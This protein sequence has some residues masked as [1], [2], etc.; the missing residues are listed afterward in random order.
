MVGSRIFVMFVLMRSGG[1]RGSGGRWMG[2]TVIGFDEG[3]RQ[4]HGQYYL[5]GVGQR[6][7]GGV[8]D[9]GGG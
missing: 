7:S 4:Q 3:G 8:G 5:I 2:D 6:R 1:G 9:L